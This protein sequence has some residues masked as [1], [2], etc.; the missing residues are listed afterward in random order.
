MDEHCPLTP[1]LIATCG[2]GPASGLTN[3]CHCLP[4]YT[5]PSGEW[6]GSDPYCASG[7]VP[8]TGWHGSLTMLVAPAIT[9]P[10]R[11]AFPPTQQSGIPSGRNAS[12][13]AS[14]GVPC[15]H[16]R[17]GPHGFPLPVSGSGRLPLLHRNWESHCSPMPM[18]VRFKDSKLLLPKRWKYGSGFASS[19]QKYHLTFLRILPASSKIMSAV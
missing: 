2:N 11:S 5:T 7:S 14:L 15:C 18:A 6:N 12:G 4:G 9:P 16:Q 1:R 3:H 10:L 13:G 8:R 17:A 19:S